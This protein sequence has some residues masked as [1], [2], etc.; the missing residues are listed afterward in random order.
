MANYF[1][2]F[3]AK[4]DNFFDQFDDAPEPDVRPPAARGLS[5]V[6]PLPSLDEAPPEEPQGLGVGGPLQPSDNRSE[7][8]RAQRGFGRSAYGSGLWTPGDFNAASS[9]PV[10][11]A[12]PRPDPTMSRAESALRSVGQGVGQGAAGIPKGAAIAQRAIADD[13][14]EAAGNAIG[15]IQQEIAGIDA[16]LAGDD[17][18]EGVRAQ[19]QNYRDTLDKKAIQAWRQTAEAEATTGTDAKPRSVDDLP[20]YKVGQSIQDAMPK[21]DPAFAGDFWTDK[22]AQGGGTMIAFMAS[23]MVP[24]V[25]PASAGIMGSGMEA[26]SLYEEAIEAGADHDTAMSAAGL[27]GLVGLA[28]VIPIMSI[29]G[30]PAKAGLLGG[31]RKIIENAGEEA[32]QEAFQTTMENLIAQ[33]HY[34]PERGTFDGVGEAALIGGILGG[35]MGSIS[36]TL[37]QPDAPPATP[38]EAAAAR[39]A[40]RDRPDSPRLT[41]GDRASALPNDV[42]DD[43]KAIQE[44]IAAGDPIPDTTAP[45][46]LGAGANVPEGAVPLGTLYQSPTPE[47]A[48]SGDRF[49]EL[50]E[51]ETV[52]GETRPTGRKVRVNLDTGQA[53]VVE[54]A[55]PVAQEA[56]TAPTPAPAPEP[57]P[58]AVY[59]PPRATP[60]PDA[61]TQPLPGNIEVL[62]S[63]GIA[64]IETDAAT[65]QYKADGDEAG[66][67]D[68]LRDVTEWD[69]NRSGIG[70][71]YEYEDGRRVMVD[72][73]QRLGLAKRAAASGQEIDFPVRTYREVDGITEAQ[74]RS[75]GAEKNIAEGSGTA[76]DAAKV[77]RDTRKT[78]KDLNLPRANQMVRDGEA[79]A[80]L[81]DQ[82]FGMVVNQVV[83]ER[84]GAIVGRL[85]PEEAKHADILGLLARVKPDNATQAEAIVRQ[86]AEAEVTE[87][88]TSLFGEEE[89]STNLYMER[90]KVLDRAMRDLGKDIS[91][92]K[93]LTERSDTI[94]AEGNLLQ[95][96]ANTA[97]VTADAAARAV[98]M[99][100]A[101]TKGPIS[102]ALTQAARQVKDGEKVATATRRFV[103]AVRGDES[104]FGDGGAEPSGVGPRDEPA[105]QAGQAAGDQTGQAEVEQTPEGAQTL[106]PGVAPITQ[107][108]R[109]QAEIDKRQAAPL[110]GADQGPGSG[111]GDLFGDPSERADLFDAPA[112]ET[113]AS[114]PGLTA[115]EKAALRA[116]PSATEDY[117]ARTKFTEIGVN[118]DGLRVF[119]DDRGVR[120]YV[121]G[122]IRHAESVGITIDKGKRGNEYLT[123]NEAADKLLGKPAEP[124]KVSPG[125][126]RQGYKFRIV[127]GQESTTQERMADDGYVVTRASNRV[128]VHNPNGSLIYSARPGVAEEKIDSAIYDDRKRPGAPTS[129]LSPEKQ[130]RLEEIKAKLAKKLGGQIN[131]GVDPEI[132]ALALEYT[133]LQIEAGAR[134]FRA[135]VQAMMDDFGLSF[136]RVGQYARNAYNSARDD[137]EAEGGDVSDMDASGDVLK[138][139][140]AMKK[141]P[142]VTVATTPT[143]GETVPDLGLVGDNT[144]D[145]EPTDGQK[146]GGN[147]KLGHISWNGLDVSIENL[148]GSERS[149]KDKDGEKWSVTMPAAYGYIRRS[150][151]ADGDHFDIYMGPNPE[152]DLVLIVD[153]QDADSGRFDEHKA[154]LGANTAEEAAAI[155]LA[156][157]SDGR[158][159]DRVRGAVEMTVDDFKDQIEGS[160]NRPIAQKG[161]G[162][163]LFTDV[164]GQKP[165]PGAPQTALT[166]DAAPQ[167]PGA[168]AIED[169]GEKIEGAAKDRWRAY[170]DKLD[171]VAD[172]EIAA[173]P[174]SKSFPA[175]DYEA[176]IED[177]IDPWTVSFIRAARD[178][179]PN[180]PRARWKLGGWVAQVTA[181]RKFSGD[182][183]SGKT[184]RA[185]LEEKFT[186]PEFKR[187]G[188]KITGTIDLY[189]EVGHGQSL[190]GL[191]LSL[192]SY[193]MKDGVRHSPHLLIW[194]VQQAARSTM[195]SNM[196]RVIASGKTREDALAA[197]KEAAGGLTPV[198]REQSER[199]VRFDIY[200]YPGR[201][202]FFIGKKIGKNTVDLE[203]FETVKE[204][205]EYRR[206]NQADLE[207]KLAKM[208]DI[209]SER[210]ATNSPRVG[211]DHRNGADVAP[212]QFSD[213]FGFRGVQFGNY[214]EGARR[215]QD[216]NEAYDGF[217]DLAGI[218]GVDPKA[219][220]L[221]GDLALAFGAR[222]KGGKGA[223]KAHY[224][225]GQI[226]INLTK[227]TGAGSLA[228]EWFHGLDNYFE[229][230]RGRKGSF[231]TDRPSALGA[232][233]GEDVR[234]EVLQAFIDLRKAINQ[235][236]LKARSAHLDKVRSTPYWT[237]GIEMHARSFESY[238]I[239]K[240][241]DLDGSNDYLANIVDEKVWKAEAALGLTEPDSYPYPVAAEVPV[242]R[243]GFD[244]LFQTI[245]AKET[246]RGIALFRQTREA[247]AE[248]ATT[249]KATIGGQVYY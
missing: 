232:P 158:G 2:Q 240:L 195:F 71:V 59:A 110:T 219:L 39:L 97:R 8:R 130:A 129:T 122:G 54:E 187:L 52:D 189:A 3:D 214:V 234:P 157:F 55:P 238:V 85:V 249:E 209:P 40:S 229:R 18:P 170:A 58:E 82:A 46:G 10:E 233:L 186:Q 162:T 127:D 165:T 31:L 222:G 142:P 104:P 210:K 156:G 74:A 73:H 72:G 67:T 81:S 6:P 66:V 114:A 61:P 136:E 193:S 188:D 41:E 43:G 106:V 109:D 33:G 57:A 151:G 204:A 128:E 175:P 155:Y 224:E 4:Q 112:A 196:P 36:A 111:R 89:V 245:E 21:P 237:T 152:S 230:G 173:Q 96:D 215:Q 30:A 79:M 217:M 148:K 243:A 226:V 147:Y 29:L 160:N 88:Q 218:I 105:P 87:T 159:L 203:T 169:F 101:N 192:A 150:E 25:G 171:E 135:I 184:T 92:F 197:F 62:D 177:G 98:L 246:D 206:D 213:A 205:R 35:G 28:E 164:E 200:R 223:A 34:D 103:A 90:A 19:L 212:E 70:I 231:I 50:D 244:N 132:V 23:A 145:A 5:M 49:E 221:N 7:D 119:E 94:A 242:I 91:T 51:T 143:D 185:S 207:A 121:E 167:A 99:K 182:I 116:E 180:K 108:D 235:T 75:L 83:T 100:Q 198:E 140:L 9:A 12:A 146:E 16:R 248:A 53:E 11:P 154:I 20:L 65:F 17:L 183:L 115:E 42:I 149:G 37:Q 113:P 78:P 93:T 44:A 239:S 236:S 202:G 139:F 77:F 125:R 168:K 166:D 191:S 178:M 131:V 161:E 69:G 153:Q 107:A 26:S 181:L 76:L 64:D 126:L 84:H 47:A 48:T 95:D 133:A 123:R 38:D 24:V 60:T 194:E 163:F 241:H 56:P 68:R 179:I 227:R 80:K 13:K 120:S 14:R 86:A 225:P 208:K 144:P 138:E 201:D 216:L 22:V 137:I 118:N 228:H 174:L 220:S 172:S 117:T 102:D 190:K 176:L 63:A 247:E 199:K 45:Q 1:D 124:V 15:F 134:K 32:A 27:G 141:A 211:V